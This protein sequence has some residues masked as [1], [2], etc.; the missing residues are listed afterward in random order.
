[1]NCLSRRR[2]S[3]QY[4]N[5]RC[6]ICYKPGV[7]WTAPNPEKRGKR[8]KKPEK[9]VNPKRSKANKGRE[10]STEEML[11][12]EKAMSDYEFELIEWGNR[13]AEWEALPD[14]IPATL[15]PGSPD[16]I[17]KV[18]RKI[19][20]L[21][22]DSTQEKF[23]TPLVE[24]HPEVAKLLEFREYAKSVS[25]YGQNFL[26]TRDRD[27]R[28]H[29]SFKQILDTGRMSSKDLNLQQ[30]PKDEGHRRCFTAPP[31][32]KL[33]IADYSQIELRVLAELGQCPAFCADFN[34]GE[35]MHIKGASRFFQ[36]P[37]EKVSKEKRQEA[38]A[39]NFGVVF[40]ITAYAL[41][42]RLGISEAMAERLIDFYYRNYEGN[43]NYLEESRRQAITNLFARTMTGRI[44]E[45]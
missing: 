21:S 37:V 39:V 42:L 10:V 13:F 3:W 5:R 9:P 33:V 34:S 30:I 2:R 6:W 11:R 44:A 4:S 20:G 29:T 38:K 8:P 36:I 25:S 1:V 18:L 23:L 45:V 27:G 28:V 26:D 32:R 12:Y 16:Q 35:D 15:N 40:G 24:K 22:L 7:D 14:E 17:K 43:R 41:A 19:C 31:G